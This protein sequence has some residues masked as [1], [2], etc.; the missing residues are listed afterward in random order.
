MLPHPGPSISLG[1]GKALQTPQ[2]QFS[3]PFV[4][5]QSTVPLRPRWHHHCAN[6]PVMPVQGCISTTTLQHP[7][8]KTFAFCPHTTQKNA[9]V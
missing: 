2:Q 6:P 1:R 9:S 3:H 5:P 4:P 8:Q 7:W